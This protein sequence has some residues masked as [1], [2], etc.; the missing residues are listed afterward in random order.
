M[1]GQIA[2]REGRIGF[3]EA[4]CLTTLSISAKVF[5]T[6]PA[7]VAELTGTAGWYMTLISA[8][9]AA[10][11]FL[12][13]CALIRR[14]P[15][16]DI[17]GIFE[18]SLGRPAGF[19]FSA[20]LAAG[21]FFIAM[22]RLSDFT[23]V[24]RVYV[25]AYSP[26]WY[27]I[28]IAVF[29]VLVMSLLGLESLARFSKLIMYILM[30]SLL[31]LLL[32]GAQNYKLYHLTPMAGY[33]YLNT[34]KHGVTRSSAYAEVILLA[35]FAKSFQGHAFIR[36]EGLLSLL[37]S[38]I[39]IGGCILCFSMTFTYQVAQEVTS[40]MYELATLIDYGRY[41]QRVEAIF[42]F[43]WILSTLISLSAVFYGFA[44]VYC[45]MFRIRDKAP[46]AV[47][48]L[49][50]LFAASMAHDSIISVI[51]DYVQPTR[52][53]GGLVIFG[54]PAAALIAARLRRKG[55]AHGA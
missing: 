31:A 24:L 2:L 3:Q 35:V 42:L 46:V 54:L 19:A 16:A 53:F 21:L 55:D 10:I 36:R 12:L 23:E 29:C 20:A 48:G 4:I 22:T 50:L 41:L 39:I 49:M 47:G 26:N 11:G 25:Y 9:T 43:I 51:F 18:Q 7:M 17:V 5:F 32:L 6:S 33:G 30:G 38:G 15:G 1:S 37:L 34:L 28:A 40:P 52:T 8:A 44:F 45:R 27:I 13:V 14:F